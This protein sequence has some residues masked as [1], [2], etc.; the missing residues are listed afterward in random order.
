MVLSV[1]APRP[2]HGPGGQAVLT[3]AIPC[4][5]LPS[6]PFSLAPYFTVALPD[7]AR[8]GLPCGQEDPQQDEMPILRDG[9]GQD[10]GH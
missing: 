7:T 5:A 9:A 3:R 2:A 8:G 4:L 1:L 10:D 6:L